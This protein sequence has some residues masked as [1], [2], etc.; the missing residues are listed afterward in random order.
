MFLFHRQDYISSVADTLSLLF[1]FQSIFEM[2]E[3]VNS[4]N[5]PNKMKQIKILKFEP[6]QGIEKEKINIA[7]ETLFLEV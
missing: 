1:L 2:D 7:N 5:T 6:I 4:S 3:N